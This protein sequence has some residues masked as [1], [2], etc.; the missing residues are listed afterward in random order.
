MRLTVYTD[1]ALRMLMYLAVKED[2]LATIADIAESYGISR[3]HLMKVAHQLGVA[4]YIE[5]VRGRQGGLRLARPSRMIGVGEV[6]RCTEPDM[7]LVPCLEPVNGQCTILACCQ[8]R[9][10]L[11]RARMAFVAVLDEYTLHD[12]VVQ[13]APMRDLLGIPA[14]PKPRQAP[15]HHNAN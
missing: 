2:G 12:L 9:T 14:M 11:Q 13:G 1:Y 7:A 6:V 3:T 5:T 10:A 8:L 15:A 4:G